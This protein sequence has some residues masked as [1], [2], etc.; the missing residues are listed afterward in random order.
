M[1]RHESNVVYPKLL[2]IRKEPSETA[3]SRLGPRERG[4]EE[5]TSESDERRMVISGGVGGVA[6]SGGGHVCGSGWCGDAPEPATNESRRL[7]SS[8]MSCQGD[9]SATRKENQI[10]TSMLDE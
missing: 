9:Y 8:A 3:A 2:R 5:R 7:A 1:K 6:G 4:D 10:S